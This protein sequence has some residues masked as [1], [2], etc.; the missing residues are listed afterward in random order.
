MS[1]TSP[2]PQEPKTE[3]SVHTTPGDLALQVAQI[4]KDSLGSTPSQS[5]TLPENLNVAVKLTGNNYS[6]WSRIIYR[7]ILGR[8]RQYHLTGTPPPPLP[9]DPRFSR[10]EQDDNSVF[11]WILQNVDASMINN[12]SRYPTAKALWD[13]LALTYGSRGDSLQ[14]FDLH[15][16]ANNIRQ[17]DDTLEACWNNLQDIWVSI[18]TLDTNPMKCPEDIS[19]YNQKMQEF[20]L[21]QFLTAVSDRFET[22]KKEL[23]KRTP[24]PNVEAAFFEF[25]R[26]ESQAGLIKHGPSEQISSLGIGQGLTVKPATGK[27]RG[28]GTD[29]SMNTIRSNNASS[30]MDKSNLLCE[31]CG[32]KGHSREKCFQIHG[33][34][35]W[36][37]GKRITTGQGKTAAARTPGEGVSSNEAQMTGESREEEE[38]NRENPR[39]Q[40][41]SAAAGMGLG[42]N[43]SPNPPFKSIFTPHAPH[44]SVLS[45]DPLSSSDIIF[46][47]PSSLNFSPPSPQSSHRANMVQHTSEFTDQPHTFPI[48]RLDTH[49]SPKYP[50]SPQPP[51]GLSH[52]IRVTPSQWI[53]DCGATDTMTFDPTDLLTQSPP[54]KSHVETASGDTIPVQASGPITITPDITLQNCLLVPSLSTK[55]LSISQ[56]T[57]A[58]DCVVL[59]YPSFCLLQD[60]R[61]QAIIGR[62]TE[63][64]GLY[65]VDAVVQHGS[66]NLATGTV[67][68]QIW[69]WHRRLG[70]PSFSYLQKLFPTLF[71]RT[72]P[73]LTCDTCLRAKQPRATY[74]SNNTRVNKVFS[75]I[76]SDVW[77]PSPHS[78]PCGFKYFVIFVDD[79]SRMTWLY[80]LRHK[81]EV[82]TKFVEFYH[83]IHTQYSSTIQILRTDNGGEYFA[84]ALQ[85]FFRDNGII[86]QTT[87]PDTPEQNGVA[88]RKNRTLLE[89]T[90]ALMLESSVPRFLW[91]EAVSTATYLSN[92]LPTVTLNHQTPLDVLASQTLIPSLLTLPPKVF[93]C[94]V[95]IHISKTHRD[96]LDPCAEKCVF[97]GYASTQKGYRCYNPRTR[98]IHVTLNCVFLETEFFFGTHPRSQGEIAT[99]GYLDW[100]PNLSW[101]VADPTRQ[102]VEPA[103]TIAPS[104]NMDSIPVPTNDIPR[105]NVLQQVNESIHDDTGSPVPFSSPPFVPN[106]TLDDSLTTSIAIPDPSSELDHTNPC[107][108]EQGRTLPP[109]KTRG[110]PP[111]RYS[112]T[113]IARATLY[114]VSTSRKNLG[115]AAKAFFTQICSE[116]IPRTVDEACSQS[117]WRDAMIMEMDALNKNNTWERCQLPPGKRTVGC[118][119]VFTV[120]YKADGTIE[121]H[122]ARLVAKGYTQ[123]YGVDYSETFSPVARI[124]TIR[125]LFAIAATENWPLHQFDVKNAF[126]HG[127][128]KE[129]VFMD[130]PPGFSKEFLPG[131]VCKLNRA[132]Y[133]LKQS[134]RAWFGRFTQAMK[135]DG[136]RQ[137]NADHTLFIKRQ[138]SLV[139]CL[140]IYVDDM[141]IT[142]NDANEISRL[143]DYLF[144][145]FEMKDLGGLK[146]FL[147]IEVLRSAEGIYISQ[148]KY[149]LDLLTEVGLLDA[150]PADTPMVQNHKLDIVQGAA[151]AD[152]EQYQRLVGKLIYLSHTRPDIA[153]AVG[154]VSQ[155]MHSPQKHHLEAVFRIM[156][157]LKGTPGRGL[158]F[159]N[160]GHLNIEAYTDADWAGSQIDRRSTSG[161]FTLV[162]GNV[163]TWRSKKQK[164]VALSSAE[165]EYRGI[166]K[167]VS[168]V[169]WIR[170]LLQELGFPVTDPTCLMCDNKASISISENPVQH[171]RTKHV[172][173]DRHFVKEKIEDGIIALPH[174]RSEDQL[175]DILTKAVNGRIFEFILRKLN[176]VDPTIQLEGEC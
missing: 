72:L 37:E 109:R 145:Q 125:V 66:S 131:Q 48:S 146:Y 155:F 168:E 81:S 27:G 95:F 151:S 148:R 116:K 167:G 176:I 175:A 50:F 94:T 144:T 29:R 93:G 68:R 92:R 2:N 113:K 159:K 43:P 149:I 79:C 80:I 30:R 133:G 115:H 117:N 110:V 21:Y 98:Q 20:R 102:V 165:A 4:L 11:T 161:Y 124:D 147:G 52:H 49:T 32:K 84:G 164:V 5:I 26:A 107:V 156:R 166:V 122:K 170:K 17:G 123:T 74:R 174:V 136:Y 157:Y 114:P 25:K 8:G 33:Y 18:D 86:H 59:M 23:L 3:S 158:L 45:P 85:Q 69:L 137:S 7:A 41:N 65:Y 103:C 38:Q 40:G 15:R 135:K 13:G 104:D 120:K 51:P 63:N 97:V 47:S 34:P 87:C 90:R 1:E 67:T 77:G 142:G 16:K 118:R 129:E 91:P 105:E 61:T 6:L 28:K 162:G 172:E 73:P 60:I 54:L 130:P 88:E 57:K 76:H 152:R 56:L 53:F 106:T 14:V 128:L 121:R 89:M 108:K 138:G 31:H 64:G 160:N 134:P 153:Y 171:D 82:A 42:E 139:T 70:H 83:M 19:L 127:T 12:V 141:I 62:G 44:F 173:I 140:I 163:V 101:S 169:L 55:L 150:K 111:D 36:W 71:S 143:R 126:L 96:K 35:E 112:P 78:T 24:L 46:P 100:L 9:T 119:W 39:A 99:D 132:L 10:W 75:L 58:L 22:E 154:V